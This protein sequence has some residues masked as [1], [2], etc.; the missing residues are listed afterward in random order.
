MD[1]KGVCVCGGGGVVLPPRPALP[2]WLN[3]NNAETVK[4]IIPVIL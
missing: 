2:C 3:L 1:R 4:A